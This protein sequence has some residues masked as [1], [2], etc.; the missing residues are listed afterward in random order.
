MQKRILGKDFSVSAVGY[1]CMGLSHAY[2]A[3]TEKNEALSTLRKAFDM[4]YTLFDTAEV[5]GTPEDPHHNELLVGEALKGIRSD[6]QIISKF[7]LTFDFT[8]GKVPIPLVPD[9]RPETIRRSVEGSLTRLRT[10]HIDLYFQHR[11]DPA[12][13]PEVVAECMS[14]LISEGKI[15]HW[16]ISQTDETYLR[17]A[18]TVCPVTAVEN[19]YSMMARGYE[20]LFGALEELSVGL[21]AFSPLANGFLTGAYR[22][23]DKFDA[24]TDYRSAMPQFTAEGVAANAELLAW[25]ESTVKEHSATPSQ[26]ALAWMLCKKP[27]I[28]PI[29]GSRNPD[30]MMENAGAAA[31]TLTADEISRM[32]AMLE[33][34]PMSGV[35]GVA[36]KN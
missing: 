14:E 10:D 31:V 1:G 29:P 4:G 28:V 2:G 22:G 26:I 21:V 9:S 23:K 3:A 16:G 11:T 32:D 17:R 24:A 12:V 18:H 35:F 20:S 33:K 6:V 5:Y 25:I 8:S 27:W 7:G 15:L 19:R 30:R 36:L 13:A 34:I